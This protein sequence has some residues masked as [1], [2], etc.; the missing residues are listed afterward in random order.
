MATDIDRDDCKQHEQRTIEFGAVTGGKA[1]IDDE[2]QALA[3]GER[4]ARRHQQR[5]AGDRKSRAM[6]NQELCE[7]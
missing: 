7:P 3:D 4:A 5:H 2:L 6:R 1:A